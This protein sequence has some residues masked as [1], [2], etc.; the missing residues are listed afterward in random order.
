MERSTKELLEKQLEVEEALKLHKLQ[1]HALIDKEIDLIE[2]RIEIIKSQ[3]KEKSP[4]EEI[5]TTDPKK[6]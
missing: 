1:K 6:W 3:I 4:L 5:K 2:K